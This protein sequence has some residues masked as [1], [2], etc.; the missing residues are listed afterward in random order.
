[1]TPIVARYARSKG[2][3]PSWGPHLALLAAA[4]L[5]APAHAQEDWCKPDTVE[6]QIRR[7]GTAPF[8]KKKQQSSAT[9]AL[10]TR[11]ATELLGT[12]A[13]QVD[14]RYEPEV[15]S[16]T[17]RVQTLSVSQRKVSG[18][19]E[20]CV[21]VQM[22]KGGIL[23]D[24][25]SDVGRA[26]LSKWHDPIAAF[27]AG[28]PLWVRETSLRDG[29]APEVDE[30]VVP[31]V[32]DLVRR[33]LTDLVRWEPDG[34]PKPA[35]VVT[36]DVRITPF[37]TYYAIEGVARDAA[38]LSISVGA[39]LGRAWIGDIGTR[40]PLSSRD[41][42]VVRFDAPTQISRGDEAGLAWESANA[43]SCRI[44]PAIGDVPTSGMIVVLP[45]TDAT[46]TLTCTDGL[47]TVTRDAT[48]SVRT[49]PPQVWL[50]AE[51]A[52]ITAGGVST[53]A[54][55]GKGLATCKLDQGVGD[56]G[57]TGQIAVRPDTTSSWTITCRGEDGSIAVGSATV[58]VDIPTT[59]TQ[60]TQIT[61]P[62]L[63]IPP[64]PVV[65]TQSPAP[66]TPSQPAMAKLY[67]RSL[68]GE[69][70]DVRVDGK[71]VA[72]FRNQQEVVVDISNG[73]HRIDV[74]PFMGDKATSSVSIGSIVN[75]TA[76]IGIDVDEPII[77]YDIPVCTPQ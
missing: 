45:T 10:R 65:V 2:R 21:V 60:T 31:R 67:I 28:R 58:A 16:L 18:G 43:R 27:A 70:A 22:P 69:W 47:R 77:C 66:I 36:F 71:V 61:V 55:K 54:W 53:I 40:Q 4:L 46:Y 1:M 64:D 15:L 56:V 14:A 57:V 41:V 74:V 68:D 59:V 12:L 13:A 24:L 8:A 25:P 39:E 63:M 37:P 29:S 23:G 48:I 26:L 32:E 52:R 7:W 6:S 73:M 33:N 72:E 17:S 35:D 50:T 19:R 42:R 9:E 20:V 11:L 34:G 5:A 49:P 44:S 51:P 76:T 75:N 30:I 38:G 62:T 3:A